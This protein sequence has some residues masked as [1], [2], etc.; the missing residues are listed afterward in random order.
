MKTFDLNA[1][2]RN[3]AGKKF[4]KRIRKA[5][6][7]PAVIY[8]GEK[9]IM[10]SLNAKELD[11]AVCTPNVYIVNITVDGK[12][13]STIVKEAQFHP[14]SDKLIHVDFYEVNDNNPITISLPITL[15][16]QA[17]GTKQGGKL[18]QVI[19]KMRVNG[20]AKNLPEMIEVDVTNLT[21]GKSIMVGELGFENFHIVE[22]KS[23]VI[24]TIKTT[25]A[26]RENE[27]EA[28]APAK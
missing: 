14:V 25:R 26:T 28:E 18:I 24:A 5:E 20:V 17:E 10:I 4:A 9:N 13:Y 23:L 22:S 7:V 11:K 2:L 27:A 3:E 8:G 12:T 1:E 6:S 19:R 15:V 16:G 21:I